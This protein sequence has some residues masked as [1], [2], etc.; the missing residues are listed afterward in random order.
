LYIYRHP[1]RSGGKK[2][3]GDGI[4]F[5]FDQFARIAS[6][7][8]LSLVLTTV[9]VAGTIGTEGAGLSGSPAYASLQA[10]AAHG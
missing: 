2:G 1:R 3:Q 5:H 9:A 6:A 4:M 10:D 7:A 8:F